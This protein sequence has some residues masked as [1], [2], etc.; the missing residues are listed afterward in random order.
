MKQIIMRIQKW[1]L[2]GESKVAHINLQELDSILTPE[3]IFQMELHLNETMPRLRFH[4]EMR[5]DD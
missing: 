1:G 5:E 2:S 4:I 3:E